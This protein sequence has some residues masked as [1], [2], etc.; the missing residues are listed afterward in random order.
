MKQMLQGLSHMH[1]KGFFHRDLKPGKAYY[2][3]YQIFKGTLCLCFQFNLS[4]ESKGS[5]SD[6]KVF[7]YTENLLVTNDVLKIAD[8]GLAREVSSMP[9]YTQYVSTRWWVMFSLVIFISLSFHMSRG[10]TWMY[11]ILGDFI[12][13]LS[14]IFCFWEFRYRAPEVLLQS[15]CYT[16]AV[17]RH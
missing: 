3:I 16:P 14:T 2:S 9:P 8:F 12:I 15:P 7:F 17:G 10:T 4:K 1:K 13:T 11:V 5:W 6:R